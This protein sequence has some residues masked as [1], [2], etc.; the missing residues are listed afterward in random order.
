MSE[1]KEINYS[2]M[3]SSVGPTNQKSARL[4]SQILIDAINPRSVCDVGCATGIWLHAFQVLGNVEKIHGIDGAWIKDWPLSVPEDAIE[5][6]DFENIAEEPKCIKD[7]EKFYLVICLE[8]AE[9][10]SRERADYL[11]DTLTQLGDV[12]YF[13][14]ATP[15][16]GGMHHVN[17]RWQSYWINKFHFR[18]YKCIDYVRP[19]IWNKYNEV[20]Y[21]YAEESFVFVKSDVL[22]NY[23]KLAEYRQERI[24]DCV[25]PEH[26]LNQ[27]IKPTHDWAWLFEIQR[28]ILKSGWQ[29]I[30]K[31]EYWWK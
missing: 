11:V 10:V 29:K 24:I 18:G 8:M 14:G 17:E 5:I 28:R 27:V 15:Q 31:R 13:S 9:H 1:N 22:D 7:G 21:F 23:A 19:K 30:K 6:Y 12:I 16:S 20:C 26:F 2:A 4:I 3:K 25:H